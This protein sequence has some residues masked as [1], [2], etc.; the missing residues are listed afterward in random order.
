MRDVTVRREAEQ[1]SGSA[2]HV[3]VYNSASYFC[4]SL[5]INIRYFNECGKLLG[6]DHGFALS[7]SIDPKSDK[8]LSIG[9]DVPT[10]AI[11]SEL[12]IN[13]SRGSL[14]EKHQMPIMAIGFSIF[15]LGLI[16]NFFR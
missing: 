2:L 6:V 14:F 7:E 12:V 13:A 4:E 3:I 1:I 11:R 8:A 16:I 9:L 5:D 15:G 10:D